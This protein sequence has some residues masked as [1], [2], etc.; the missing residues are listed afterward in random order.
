MCQG[1]SIK[2]ERSAQDR[3]M[4]YGIV[5]YGKIMV[6]Y[7]KKI[8]PFKQHTQIKQR[9]LLIFF[10]EKKGPHLEPLPR[11][12]REGSLLHVNVLDL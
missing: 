11:R 5:C 1:F 8:Q 3:G 2:Q 12:G 4:L 10:Q 9:T 7:G 6:Y